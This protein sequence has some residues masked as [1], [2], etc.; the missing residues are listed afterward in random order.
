MKKIILF[1]VSSLFITSLYAQT[2][3]QEL[4][5]T[6]ALELAKSEKKLVFIDC[7]TS[8]CGPCKI[9][10]KEVLPQKEVG[11][12]LNELFVCV[13]Y[14]MEE[15]EGPELAKKYKVDAYPTF[16]LLNADGELINSIVGMTP[17]GGEFIYKVKL[18]LGEI[19]T[20]KMD[21]MYAVGNRMTRFVLSYLKA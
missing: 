4:S 13:K 19:S 7:Y 12:F 17:M 15:G 10:A 16:L 9:M 5:L 20:V 18:A 3:F 8:W 6:K 1:I 14:D 21:S 2:K 11:D